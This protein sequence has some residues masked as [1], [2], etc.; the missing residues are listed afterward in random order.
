MVSG[1]LLNVYENLQGFSSSR[2]FHGGPLKEFDAISG[3]LA[4][5]VR[6]IEI[7]R[8]IGYQYAHMVDRPDLYG[9]RWSDEMVAK[10][11][12]YKYFACDRAA[13]DLGRV[14]NLMYVFGTDRDWDVE[15]HWRDLKIIQL[16]MGGKQLC[17]VKTARW[18][19]G[20]ETL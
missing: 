20:C 8:I 15:K 14:I 18:F 1:L 10:G 7:I 3:V 19:Y 2:R 9:E 16:W 17:Q 4:D 13:E 5:L 6:D 11:R 12:A